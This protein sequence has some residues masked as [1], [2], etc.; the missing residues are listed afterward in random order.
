MASV[1]IYARRR[2]IALAARFE[3]KPD[4]FGASYLVP[5]VWP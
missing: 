5:I 1:V 2:Q 3:I 4:H